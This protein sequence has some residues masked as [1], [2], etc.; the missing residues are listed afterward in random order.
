MSGKRYP[1]EFKIEAIK[2]VVDLFSR[3]VIGWSIQP[4]T[5][6]DIALKSHD[7]EGRI[8]R[9]GNSHDNVVETVTNSNKRRETMRRFLL[10]K[11][12]TSRYF[13]RR[14]C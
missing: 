2:Q 4:R 12:D 6:K 10:F 7:L 5:T 3:H 8:S 14:G 11:Y 1:E 13:L 9:R